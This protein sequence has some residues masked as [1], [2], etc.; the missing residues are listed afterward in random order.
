MQRLLLVTL[1]CLM[2]AGASGC[3]QPVTRASTAGIVPSVDGVRTYRIYDPGA[4]RALVIALHPLNGSARDFEAYTHFDQQAH[5]YGFAVVYPQGLKEAWNAGYC[6]PAFNAVAADDVGFIRALVAQFDPDGRPVFLLG[7]SNGGMLAY[8]LACEGVPHLMGAVVV[9]TDAEQCTP[10]GPMP[11]IIQFQGT[12]DTFT[13]NRLW[14]LRDGLWHRQPGTGTG[15][16]ASWGAS[17]KLVSV[18]RGT[19]TWYQRDPDVSSE[20][21][22]FFARLTA[23]TQR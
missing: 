20:A 12:A 14:A 9:G 16:W 3:N 15:Y 23:G 5:R 17:V 2:V 18:P 19:H 10:A 11:A 21:G 4:A 6:C 1:S 22:A 7:L 13:G 8:R